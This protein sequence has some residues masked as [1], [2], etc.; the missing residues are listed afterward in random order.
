M[1]EHFTSSPKTSK[2]FVSVFLSGA[3]LA[4]DIAETLVENGSLG[5]L[6]LAYFSAS[7][8]VSPKT[9]TEWLLP[10][11]SSPINTTES[12]INTYSNAVQSLNAL[13]PI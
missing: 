12:G 9:I 4:A 3:F 8:P 1:L 7:D 6:A 5:K 10:N 13:S 11:K 2:I